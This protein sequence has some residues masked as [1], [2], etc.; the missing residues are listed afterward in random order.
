MKFL[1]GDEEVMLITEK[2][3]IIRLEHGGNLDHRPQHPGRAADPARRGRPPRFGGAP[4]RAGR[5]DEGAG[6]PRPDA[7]W[8]ERHGSE[9]CEGGRDEESW[10]GPGGPCRGGSRASPAAH[11]EKSVVDQYFNAVN[12]KDTQTLSSFAAVT[13]D[14]K[15]DNW[16]IK[17]TA[18]RE[19]KT[20]LHGSRRWREG[21]ATLEAAVA[22]NTKDA[23]T[24]TSTLR[25]RRV[26]ALR[27]GR[28]ARAGQ[29]AGLGGGQWDKF[30]ARGP[31]A[32]EAAR[33]QPRRS[34]E[35]EK[36]SVARSVGQS[37]TSRAS[38]GEVHREDSRARPHHRRTRS[39]ALRDDPAQVRAEA[40]GAACGQPLGDDRTSSRRVLSARLASLTRRLEP[41]VAGHQLF[42]PTPR[43]DTVSFRSSPA[44]SRRTTVPTPNRGWRTRTPGRISCRSGRAAAARRR[45]GAARRSSWRRSAVAAASQA[46]ADP[47]LARHL[48]PVARDLGQEPAGLGSDAA[49][50]TPAGSG[51]RSGAAAPSRASC[52]RRRAGAP[53]RARPGSARLR[54]WGDE[55]L[56]HA[57]QEHGLE[58]Q[59]LGRV[60][61][62]ERRRARRP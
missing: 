5:R 10:R 22:P 13:F 54:V 57:H 23:R 21:Q 55:P 46:G 17:E 9:Q 48:Q 44:P 45:P 1:R 19:Q 20:P 49:G 24:Y 36:R 52:P 32:Q 47:R 58:L 2:G 59:A 25:G 16:E 34:V 28:Q 12:A 51:P 6:P 33:P 53:P 27:R 56:L 7:R 8:A 18:R 61:R 38:P 15:V 42:A 62:H 40:R 31:R 39:P 11:P 29:A 30:N 35:K 37:T 4:G 41:G 14:K 43:N 60:E 3:M 50:R 26:K